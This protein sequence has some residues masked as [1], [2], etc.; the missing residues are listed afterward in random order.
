[1][2]TKRKKTRKQMSLDELKEELA[3]SQEMPRW[4]AQLESSIALRERALRKKEEERLKKIEARELRK[5]KTLVKEEKWTE[6]NLKKG[7]TY[8]YGI[9]D[10]NE[11]YIK[12]GRSKNPYK[13]LKGIQTGCPYD[14]RIKFLARGGPLVESVFHKRLKDFHKAGEWFHYNSS[15]EF[16]LEHFISK[17]PMHLIEPSNTDLNHI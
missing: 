6:K 5:Y 7:Q 12:I 2:K 15:V 13:R 3:K 1:M 8:L 10:E 9:I 14:L 16:L 11:K 17:A 4:K